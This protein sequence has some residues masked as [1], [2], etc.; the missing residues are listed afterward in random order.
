[1]FDNLVVIIIITLACVLIIRR[2]IKAI[3][4]KETA[5]GCSCADN[6]AG[7]SGVNAKSCH[8]GAEQEKIS[9]ESHK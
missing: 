2:I 7:C 9:G 4:N 8:T 6:C 3:I 1:M 5:C